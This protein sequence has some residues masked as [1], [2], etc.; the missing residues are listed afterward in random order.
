MSPSGLRLT[1][2]MRL[3]VHYT[4]LLVIPMIAAAVVTQFSVTYPLWQRAIL[5]LIAGALFFAA[6]IIRELILALIAARKGIVVERVTLFAFGG[7]TQIDRDTSTPAL[8]LTLSLLGLLVNLIMAGIFTV[9]YFILVGTDSVLADILAQWLAFIWLMLAILHFVPGFPLD[10]GKA[11]RALLWRLTGS[12]EK[13]TR[14]A[15]WTGWVMGLIAIAGGI[16]LLVTTKER[17]AGAF[18]IAVGLVLQNAATHGR[19]LAG[20]AGQA[21]TAETQQSQ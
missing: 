16:F 13:A 3:R 15:S 2:R 9:V 8:E 20:K 19:R 12:Y 17:F 4:W 18:F 5:G 11:L 6:L 10:G 7:L 21:H 1:R 14:A